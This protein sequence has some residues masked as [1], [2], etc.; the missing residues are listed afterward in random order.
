MVEV[1]LRFL[2]GGLIVSAFAVLGDFFERTT[3]RDELAES[4]N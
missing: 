1:I 3:P 2:A 4:L